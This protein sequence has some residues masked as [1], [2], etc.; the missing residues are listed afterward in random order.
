MAADSAPPPAAGDAA[1]A[2][3][4]AEW[5][6]A[7]G[8][9]R[10]L[11]QTDIDSLFGGAAAPATPVLRSGF[12]A[13]VRGAVSGTERL[14]A[15]NVVVDRL[16]RLMT[17]S[18]R[19]FTGDNTDVSIERVRSLRL[20]DFL[21]SIALP[22]M[23][24]VMR[25]EQWDGYCL[26]ALDSRLIGSVVD[27]LLGGRRNRLQP[28][29]G[30]PYTAIERLFV[31]RLVNEVLLR[32]FK[33]AFES[34][35]AVDFTLDRFEATPT[36][37][38]ITKLSAPA[39]TFR[40]EIMMDGRGGHIDVLIP[41]AALEPVR[42]VLSQDFVGKRHGGDLIWHSHLAAELPRTQ[43]RL[44]AVLGRCE[45]SP[46]EIAGWRVGTQLVLGSR[47]D[48]PVDLFCDDLLLLRARIAEKGGRVALLVEERLIRDDLP[49]AAAPAGPAPAHDP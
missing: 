21:D 20:K 39:V 29:E 13:L 41:Y 17:T 33:T 23:I 36:F 32:D 31:E 37:A 49:A 2:A 7:A 16:A 34:I 38:A 35:G 40:A 1:D 3:L 26:A 46:A 14:P 44:R 18:M 24:A 6:A 25:I 8:N 45:A 30:R 5:A 27:V 42:D 22:A 15:L 11:D 10:A 43:V 48:E 12:E 9:G 4:A 28:I 19:K 47:Q